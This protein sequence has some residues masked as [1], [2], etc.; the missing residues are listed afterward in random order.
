MP[1]AK[2]CWSGSELVRSSWPRSRGELLVLLE[3]RE[4]PVVG[5][6]PCAGLDVGEGRVGGMLFMTIELM[7][8]PELAGSPPGQAIGVRP[9]D[10][11]LSQSER[12]PSQSV[13][14][15]L[16]PADSKASSLKI[17]MLKTSW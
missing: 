8:W 10:F 17:G 14:A 2:S 3:G 12:K 11:S 6:L 13:G 7:S 5:D 16:T 4:E 15:E 9:L 1:L